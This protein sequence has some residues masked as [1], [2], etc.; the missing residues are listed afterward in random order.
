M[1]KTVHDNHIETNFNNKKGIIQARLGLLFA[2]PPKLQKVNSYLDFIVQE[3]YK[4]FFALR[5]NF[6]IAYLTDI[7]Q[8]ISSTLKHIIQSVGLSVNMF[9][10]VSL[11]ACVCLCVWVN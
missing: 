9:V 1:E 6:L 5:N 7:Y 10:Y 3:D 11:Y 8:S 2:S 4:R